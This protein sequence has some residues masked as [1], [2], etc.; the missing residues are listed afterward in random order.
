M[1]CMRD[2]QQS[3]LSR[4]DV[5]TLPRDGE[6]AR[7]S[8]GVHARHASVRL[9]ASHDARRHL[10]ERRSGARRCKRAAQIWRWCAKL[11]HAR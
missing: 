9:S 4:I 2:A 1:L 10:L 7:S 8:G 11:C 6:S 5:N 3:A